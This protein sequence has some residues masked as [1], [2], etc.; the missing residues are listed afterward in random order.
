MA[1]FIIVEGLEQVEEQ[2]PALPLDREKS[3][4]I[5]LRQGGDETEKW[6]EMMACG[7]ERLGLSGCSA[8][9]SIRSGTSGLLWPSTCPAC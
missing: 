9:G 5:R 8:L 4:E 7:L 6:L 3:G 1:S 2:K